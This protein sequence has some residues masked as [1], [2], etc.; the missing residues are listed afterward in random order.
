MPPDRPCGNG[1]PCDP[2]G[3]SLTSSTIGASLRVGY[4]ARGAAVSVLMLYQLGNFMDAIF[5]I[6]LSAAQQPN[7]GCFDDYLNSLSRRPT[8]RRIGVL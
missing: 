5:A 2:G 4:A 6:H 3:F 7:V 8:P 1:R